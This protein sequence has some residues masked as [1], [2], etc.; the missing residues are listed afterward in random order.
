MCLKSEINQSFV[1][2]EDEQWTLDM[3]MVHFAVTRLVSK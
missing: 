3:K 2:F 1:H